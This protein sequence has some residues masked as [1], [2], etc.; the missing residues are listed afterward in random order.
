MD[1][2]F[3]SE[4]DEQLLKL[5]LKNRPMFSEELIDYYLSY[6]GCSVTEKSSL[7]LISLI[8]HKSLDNLVDQSTVLVPQQT[9]TD[10]DKHKDKEKKSEFTKE[11]SCKK[12]IKTLDE[13]EKNYESEEIIKKFNLFKQ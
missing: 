1:D 13:F 4:K 8:L 10:K 7:R 6:S 2:N 3:V 5:L 11:L 12:L 9:S